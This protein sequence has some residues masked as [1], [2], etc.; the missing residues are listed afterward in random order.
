MLEIVAGWEPRTA[1]G[2]QVCQF[3]A[4]RRTTELI[5]FTPLMEKPLRFAGLYKRPHYE[6]D[7][8]MWDAISD[9]PMST[10]FACSRFLT[11]WLAT[12]QW[13]LFCDFADMMFLADP[14]QLFDLADERYAVMVVKHRHVPA[15][16]T[17]MDDQ[18]QTTYPR[19]NW[20]SVILWNTTHPANAR[21][22][23]DMVNDLPGRDL[24]AFCWLKDEEIG[25]LPKEWNWLVGVDPETAADV[26][27]S[28]KLLHFTEGIPAIRGYEEGPW[29][30]VWRN[31]LM[32]MDATRARIPIVG[33]A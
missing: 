14:V 10:S 13:A 21:L 3:S 22:T 28:P 6:R 29:A 4:I 8:K 15:E 25:L 7:G 30:G 18:V 5:H 33:L 27:I 32:I 9:A 20:S 11:P 24:H 17:K 1:I 26:G 19:K 16:S 12:S 2:Y 31:E 23:V